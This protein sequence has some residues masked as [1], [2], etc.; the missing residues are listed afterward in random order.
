MTDKKTIEAGGGF[1][2]LTRDEFREGVFRRDGWRCVACGAPAADAHHVV[3]RRL[4]PDGGYYLENGASLCA[5]HHLAAEA[6][7]LPCDEIRRL[8]GIG[9]FPIP[10][11]LYGDQ[12]YDKWGNPVLPNGQRLRGELFDDPSVQ[13]ILA[14]V[15]SLFT[16]RVKYPRTYHLPWSPGVDKDDR[17]MPDTRALEDGEVVATA[18]MDGECTTLYSDYMHARSTDYEPHPSRS[19]A[20]AMHARVAHDIPPGWRVC[21]ENLHA[22]HSIRYANLEAYF[23]VFSVWDDA[24]ECL[25]WDET[26]EW[27]ALLG[28]QTVPVIYR[29]PWDE[30]ALRGL[31]RPE[32]DGDPCEGHVVRVAGRLR[33]RDFR[34]RV[35]KY[36][37][38][39]HVRDHGHWSRRGF[40]PN[41][42][43]DG[44]RDL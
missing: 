39:G 32:R 22:A 16:T 29:G 2:L 8:A 41:G 30:R 27:A 17:V 37:R 34:F 7:T 4:W 42:L 43:R 9:R 18:K 44:A 38:A 19:R 1:A 31:H 15:L 11:H 20:R 35:G 40:V 5:A 23:M 6:T 10:P 36:V 13:K 24:N 26:A 12:P 3:E 28:L 21:G 25:S 33:Y 14:P